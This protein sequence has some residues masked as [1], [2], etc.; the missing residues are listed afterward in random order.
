MLVAGEVFKD[1]ANMGCYLCTP[2]IGLY[3]VSFTYITKSTTGDYSDTSITLRRHQALP[4]R[5]WKYMLTIPQ[6]MALRIPTQCHPDY[7]NPH[8][9]GPSKE[10]SCKSS[11]IQVGKPE[12]ACQD[13]LY[14]GDLG[15]GPE[16]DLTRYP[17]PAG[18]W[19]KKVG[20][21]KSFVHLLGCC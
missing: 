5:F 21:T 9:F 15:W 16:W 10:A 19:L 12:K 4:L 17:D 3:K 11:G 14:W 6:I 20:P 18:N 13:W 2:P 1:P 8:S 7:C